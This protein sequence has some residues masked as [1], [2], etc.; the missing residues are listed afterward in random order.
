[1]P[2]EVVYVFNPSTWGRDKSILPSFRPMQS[3]QSVPGQLEQDNDIL[4]HKTRNH[5]KKAI[6]PGLLWRQSKLPWADGK[7]QASKKGRHRERESILEAVLAM[8]AEENEW[9]QSCLFCHE[10]HCGIP[11]F[12]SSALF[13]DTGQSPATEM[14]PPEKNHIHPGLDPFPHDVHSH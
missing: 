10:R 9:K 6:E 11:Q 12:I 4:S 7:L 8:E 14:E 3:I 13:P 2:G 5:H 1:M